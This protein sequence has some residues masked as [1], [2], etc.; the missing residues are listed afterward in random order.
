MA[1][2]VFAS[3]PDTLAEELQEWA[4]NQGRSLSNLVG[5]LLE[6]AVKEAKERGDFQPKSKRGN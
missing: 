1:K 4:D 6:N 5:Y 3:V 2:R